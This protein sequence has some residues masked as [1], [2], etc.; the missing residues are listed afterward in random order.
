MSTSINKTCMQQTQFVRSCK[1]AMQLLLQSNSV[2]QLAELYYNFSI[3]N[4]LLKW[5]TFLLASLT[6][7]LTV[8]LFSIY[9]FLLKL[10]LVLQWLSI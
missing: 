3:S 5:L 2:T 4:D 9:S 6:V 10:V 1:M 8:L 7:S